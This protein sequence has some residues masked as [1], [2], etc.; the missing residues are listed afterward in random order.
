MLALMKDVFAPKK[1]FSIIVAIFIIALTVN[2]FMSP[3][4]IAAGG[5][6][7][8]AIVLSS[9]FQFD[10]AMT[11]L[12]ANRIIL[13]AALIFLGE[14]MFFNTVI[15]SQLLPLALW[16]IPE[17]MLID[18]RMLSMVAGSIL[19]AISMSMMYANRA[20]SGGTALPP[21]IFKKYF[22]LNTSIGLFLSDGTVVVL[23]FFVFGAESFIYAIFSILIT[24][25]AMNYIET[26]LNKKKMVFILSDKHQ[27]ITQDIMTK[28]NRGV[29][30]IPVVGAYRQEERRM[31]MVT[32]SRRDYQQLRVIVEKHDPEAFMITDTVSDVHGRGFTYEFSDA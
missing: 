27:E 1:L 4:E 20:S 32:L 24:M 7:G 22:K 15:G 19:F 23:S 10:V 25:A 2:L 26:G 5:I 21:L 14:E 11:V 16:L 6:T 18:D 17:Y 3:H 30:F 13:L 8:L 28:V 9:A 12:I 29:T 31:I